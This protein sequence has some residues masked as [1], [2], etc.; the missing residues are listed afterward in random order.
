MAVI[1]EQIA[2]TKPFDKF[3]FALANLAASQTDVV[4]P[5]LGAVADTHLAWKAGCIVGYSASLTAAIAAGTLKAEVFVAGTD[6]G[7]D[8]TLDTASTTAFVGTY[9]YGTYPFAAGATLGVKYTSNG[10]LSP[11][12]SDA[13]ITLYVLYSDVRV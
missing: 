2:I 11:E 5:V 1:Q 10:S 3:E 4:I 9:E 6:N 13:V 7:I 8:I 12:T